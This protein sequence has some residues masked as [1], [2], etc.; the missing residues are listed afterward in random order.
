MAQMKCMHRD[1]YPDSSDPGGP[2]TGDSEAVLIIILEL[3]QGIAHWA[4]T[5]SAHA[6]LRGNDQQCW[7]SEALPGDVGLQ[8]FPAIP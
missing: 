4:A 3:I 5:Y 8:Q 2:T 1:V 6:L 7:V